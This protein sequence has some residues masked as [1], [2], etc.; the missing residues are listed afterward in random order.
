MRK[1]L[2]LLVILM[3]NCFIGFAQT[4][5]ERRTATFLNNLNQFQ[6]VFGNQ[7]YPRARAQDVAADDNTYTCSSKLTA[8]R[9]SSSSFRSS[10]VSSLAL[11]GFGFTIPE[12]ATIQNISV[13][14]RRF[15]KGTPSVGDHIL[16]LM[17]RYQQ[18]SANEP[19]RYGVMWSYLDD[20]ELD[21]PGRI[22]PA[23][24]TEYLFSQS[25]SG[26]NGGV[27]H[28]QPYQ[29][30]PAMVNAVTFGVRIDNYPPI[31]KGSAQACYDFV[32]VTVEYSQP[33]PGARKSPA[34]KETKPVKEPVVYPN[35]FTTK[36]NIQFTASESGRAAVELYNIAGTKIRILF[37]ANVVQGEVYNA[38]FG[39]ALLPG[40]VYVYTISNGKQKHT[41]RM[42]KLE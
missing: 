30:T 42:I 15:K 1:Y 39:D 14:V 33:E 26:N 32:E 11:Q 28:N 17:Q 5:P 29:W 37:S 6:Q 23:A 27:N 7:N 20:E 2:L 22:Y 40:G 10:S 35:P 8:I 16:S 12:D 18:V 38:S 9:D 4:S 19:G 36:A 34:I 3:A 41:G 31:G 13:K 21:Y 24:E 25:G